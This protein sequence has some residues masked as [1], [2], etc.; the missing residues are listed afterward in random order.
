MG[1]DTTGLRVLQADLGKASAR[2][3]AAASLVV[4]KTAADIEATAKIHA[5]VDTGALRNS[6]SSDIS[7]LSAEIGP[8]VDYGLYVEAGTSRAAPQPY[9]GPAADVHGPA[10][11]AAIAQIGTKI[12]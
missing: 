7:V 5:P 3:V 4:R 8:T 9:M 11:E 2:T 6:I 10:F 12:L 1:F